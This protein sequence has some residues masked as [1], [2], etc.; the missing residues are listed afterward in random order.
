MTN[1]RLPSITPRKSASV[2]WRIV[3][4][5]VEACADPEQF[6]FDHRQLWSS[7]AWWVFELCEWLELYASPSVVAAIAPDSDHRRELHMAACRAASLCVSR[8]RESFSSDHVSGQCAGAARRRP[9]LLP[10]VNHASLNVNA[11]FRKAPVPPLI[12]LVA[13]QAP[14]GLPGAIHHAAFLY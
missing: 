1:S 8:D 2:R 6:L 13:V 11:I 14:A 10:S 9:G 5:P 3:H 4:R 12:I 7:H